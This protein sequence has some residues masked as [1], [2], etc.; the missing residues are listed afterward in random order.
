M[1]RKEYLSDFADGNLFGTSF[2]S[3]LDAVAQDPLRA[4]APGPRAL[5]DSSE[6]MVAKAWTLRADNGEGK[7]WIRGARDE[8]RLGWE[9]ETEL[10]TYTGDD[11]DELDFA[12]DQNGAPLVVMERSGNLWIRYFKAGVG[13]FVIE[14]FGAGVMPRVILDDPVH[15][16]DSDLVV[17]Y[18][19]AGEI[20]IREQ[21][22][23]YVAETD[24]GV[25]MSAF[26]TLEG[27]VRDRSLRVSVMIGERDA[28]P[29]TW[30]LTRE[31]SYLYPYY[32]PAEAMA[33]WN[34]SV[35]ALIETVI[36]VYAVPVEA[37]DVGSQAVSGLLEYAIWAEGILDEADLACEVVSIAVPTKVIHY[38]DGDVDEM[39]VANVSMSGDLE[40][41]IIVYDD[42]DVDEMDV[43]NESI[44]GTL[45]VP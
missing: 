1:A 32:H 21:R 22:D 14:D 12:F 34:R 31:T 29:G 40:T 3:R 5:N 24:M 39:D 28:G 11:I 17:F 43:A 20:R 26:Q 44:S 38:D 15:V 19:R 35:D 23:L 36:I 45:V 18:V 9:E 16:T 25:V 37:M 33:V 6:G 4:L 2:L 41:V 10:F 8:I 7:V 42:G 27:T 30:E 13:D